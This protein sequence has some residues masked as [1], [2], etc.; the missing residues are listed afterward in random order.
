[1]RRREMLE[2]AVLGLLHESPLH[3]YELRRRLNTRLGAFRALSF[4]TLYPALGR[5]LT[6]G[7][8][9]EDSSAPAQ[10]GRRPRGLFVA[11]GEYAQIDARVHDV[12]P[13]RVGVVQRN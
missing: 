11:G 12:D 2:F 4:G 7:L 8:I 1:M 10:P 9:A 6:Q 5:L 3:G 13:C